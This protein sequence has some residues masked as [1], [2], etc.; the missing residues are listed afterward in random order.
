MRTLKIII[1]TGAR[2]NARQPRAHIDRS[3]LSDRIPCVE[4]YVTPFCRYLIK[5]AYATLVGALL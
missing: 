5:C 2:S 3:V 1:R 4:I